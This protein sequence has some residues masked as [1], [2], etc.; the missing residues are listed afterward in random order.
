M[1]ILALDTSSKSGSVALVKDGELM[2]EFLVNAEINHSE[3]I[4]PAIS[5]TLRI[6]KTGLSEVDC[7]AFAMGPGA[8]TGL[9]IGAGIIKGLVLAT[10]KPVIG[11]SSLDAL[12]CNYPPEGPGSCICPMLDAK[13]DEV[14]AAVYQGE[15]SGWKKIREDLVAPPREFLK[16]AGI[17]NGCVF[18]GDGALR[19]EG[20]IRETLPGSCR[21]LP[22][23]LGLIRASAVGLLGME[24]FSRGNFLDLLTFTP[25]YLRG[26][27]AETA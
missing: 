23:A 2:A 22:A 15:G 24:E 6:A 16:T 27:P 12:A 7:F 13:R 11:V 10:G 25:V 4:M 19:Y 26:S 14:Y 3:T 5:E 20:L 8:F 21:V 9:R 1:L 18:L 17:R